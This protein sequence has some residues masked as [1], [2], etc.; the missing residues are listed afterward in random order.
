M[1]DACVGFTFQSLYA[2]DEVEQRARNAFARLRFT[3]PIIATN[4]VGDVSGPIPRSWVYAPVQSL[5]ELTCWMDY[6][7]CTVQQDLNVDAFVEDTSQRRLPYQSQN[8]SPL[9]FRCYLLLG[10]NKNYGLYFHGPHA[11][12]DGGPTLSAFELM[13]QWMTNDA[14]EPAENL[15]WGTEWHNLPL[16]P[17]SA[18][19]GPREDWN[20]AGIELLK[21]L[22]D[23]E[24]VRTIPLTVRPFRMSQTAVG[25]TRRLERVL[26]PTLTRRLVNK[27]RM[28]G[29]S[30][31]HL[32]EAAYCMV[33]LD[34]N[35][36][37]PSVW[38]AYH[39]LGNSSAISLIP[40][41]KLPYDTR[42]HFISSRTHIPIQIS[43]IDISP[44]VSPRLQLL[45][46]AQ[47]IEERYT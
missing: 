17:V 4:I 41:L 30:M 27:T 38:D 21:Q 46:I 25:K 9:W 39:F 22:S 34:R 32:F 36:L 15:P 26:D 29:C 2:A 37:L 44:I 35:Q 11:I 42:S 23:S 8:A 18:T 10:N 5:S 33:L 45:Q 40:H 14:T 47:A 43:M 28:V 16:G 3:C 1:T 13:F 20:I 7:F 31:S 19:G 12:M 6:A 24:V